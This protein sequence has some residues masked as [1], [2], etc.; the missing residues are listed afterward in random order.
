MYV[1]LHVSKKV[2]FAPIHVMGEIDPCNVGWNPM[3]TTNTELTELILHCAFFLRR[4]YSD[5]GP[6][7]RI[8]PES[9]AMREMAG[10]S[11]L[12]LRWAD[13]KSHESRL[14]LAHIT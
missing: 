11:F 14:S 9:H 7:A 8:R 2:L 3:L 6:T 10:A 13:R 1:R 5:V 12:G 4:R